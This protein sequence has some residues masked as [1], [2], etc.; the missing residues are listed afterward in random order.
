MKTV[1]AVVLFGLLVPSPQTVVVGGS[2]EHYCDSIQ[3][4]ANLHVPSQLKLKG[5]IF[6]ETGAT[7]V[8]SAVELR[9]WDSGTKQTVVSKVL[10]DSKGRFDLGKVDKGHYRLIA[11]P[12]RAFR[13]ADEMWC[14]ADAECVLEI[15]LRA[16]PTDLPDSQCPIE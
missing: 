5:R 2:D 7:F 13:Q 16:N 15:S 1:L 8:K 9:R 14:R 10:T 11:S 12:T 6:D 3:V 4:K